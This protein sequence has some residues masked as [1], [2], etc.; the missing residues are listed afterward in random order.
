MNTEGGRWAHRQKL[1]K[2]DFRG[3]FFSL[4]IYFIY[5]NGKVGETE[6]KISSNCCF[7]FQSSA[8]SWSYTRLNPET[9]NSVLASHICGRHLRAYAVLYCFYKLVRWWIGS[10]QA[11]TWTSAVIN[12]AT[13]GL[14]LCDT[15]HS[16]CFFF[17]NVL[18]GTSHIPEGLMSMIVISYIA[19]IFSLFCINIDGY[20]IV[21]LLLRPQN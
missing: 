20:L 4:K 2:V 8:N 9:G 13:K 15:H 16:D 7:T 6:K 19:Y 14:T 10:R 21:Y 5:L 12:T 17:S 1:T 11:R 18:E 3:F